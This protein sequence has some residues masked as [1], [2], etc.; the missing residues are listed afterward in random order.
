MARK[1][2]LYLV[3]FL[4]IEAVFFGLLSFGKQQAE[5]RYI[6]TVLEQHRREYAAILLNPVKTTFALK[7]SGN[8]LLGQL[9]VQEIDL[10]V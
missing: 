5:E 2:I 4:G 6:A 1:N 7:D 10:P 9:T 8:G 3:L